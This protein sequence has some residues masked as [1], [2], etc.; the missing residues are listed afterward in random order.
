[1]FNKEVCESLNTH[2][3]DEKIKVV[4]YLIL[5]LIKYSDSPSNV[6]SLETIWKA[7]IIQLNFR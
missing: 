7:L 5:Y 6:K 4:L 3:S 2:C 1:M